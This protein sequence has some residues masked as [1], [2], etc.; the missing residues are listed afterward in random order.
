[1]SAPVEKA[2]R[3]SAMQLLQM[4]A[5]EKAIKREPAQVKNN[6]STIQF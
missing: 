5:P 3:L 4:L 6:D 2:K 1:M